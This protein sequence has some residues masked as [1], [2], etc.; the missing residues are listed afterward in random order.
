M[1]AIKRMDQR[2]VTSSPAADNCAPP[3]FNIGVHPCPSAV[4]FLPQ[5]VFAFSGELMQIERV[6]P[7]CFGQ[8]LRKEN[9]MDTTIPAAENQANK[10]FTRF[11]PHIARVLLG[12]AFLFFGVI[13]LLHLMKTPDD[14]PEDF[15]TVMAGLTKGGYLNVVSSAEALAGALLLINRFVPLAL[16]LLAPILVGILTFHCALNLS[17]IVPGAILTVLELYLAWCYRKAFAPMLSAKVSP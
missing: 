15:K 3:R 11:F 16:A 4:K 5:S 13:G 14:L 6:V 7:V 2:L 9:I 12:M 10:S 8:R 17:G 1:C